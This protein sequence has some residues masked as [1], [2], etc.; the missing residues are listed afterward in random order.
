MC[1][2]SPRISHILTLIYVENN[3]CISLKHCR[4]CS[5][6]TLHKMLWMS[7]NGILSGSAPGAN[8]HG[9]VGSHYVQA[10]NS[11]HDPISISA[12]QRPCVTFCIPCCMIMNTGSAKH[13]RVWN[14]IH[15]TPT[16][17]L[18]HTHNSLVQNTRTCARIHNKFSHARILKTIHKTH[19]H[20]H[21][22]IYT[23]THTHTHTHKRYKTSTK[24][25]SCTNTQH[26]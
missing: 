22:H 16:H 21:T 20:I 6:L 9:W 25:Q 23:H 26:N 19:T 11:S 10:W 8:R 5:Y 24:L 18:T 17:T 1:V 3:F 13:T 4:R 12:V 7:L 15:K 2:P 14:T